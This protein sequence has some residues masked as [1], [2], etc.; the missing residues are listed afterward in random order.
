M[1]IE[2]HLENNHS[3]WEK[4]EINDQVC[5]VQGD[6]F[7][8]DELLHG[9]AILS[10]ISSLSLPSNDDNDALKHLLLKCNGS[11]ALVIR[12]SEGLLCA[13]DRLRSFP[14]F[15]GKTDSCLIISDDANYLRHRIAAPFDEENGA[16]FLL[17]GFVTGPATLF[18]GIYQLQAGEALTLTTK[19]APIS[20]FYYHRF[21]HEDYFSDSE[22]ELLNRLDQV[23]LQVFKR[24]IASIKEHDLQIVVPLSGGLDSRIIVS[25]L[26]RCGVE[27]VICFS[28]GRKRSRQAKISKQVAEALGYQWYFVEYSKRNC[29]DI[30][31]EEIRQ[32]LRFA[33]NFASA[34][35]LQDFFAVKKLKEDKIIPENA[36]FMPGHSGDMLA[37]SHI[38]GECTRSDCSDADLLK[39]IIKTHYRHWDWNP[40]TE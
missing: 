6:L 33:G 28:Y 18:K 12:T 1:E 24:L 2:I 38:P 32:Y 3:P 31:S 40:D 36:V 29:N 5:W 21:W 19:N 25:M 39:H 22:E 26:K 8:N 14:I 23:F 16:E 7:Y 34:P 37:G 4:T 9:H 13:V 20:T 15:Y 35:H 11:F 27:N 17:T 10:L 30:Q